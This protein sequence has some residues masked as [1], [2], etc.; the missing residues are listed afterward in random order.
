M[1]R[2]MVSNQGVTVEESAQKAIILVN[3]REEIL[4]L[5][6]EIGASDKTSILRFSPFP[7]EPKAELA[8]PT[9][10]EQ[11]GRLAAFAELAQGE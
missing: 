7:A 8:A 4:I 11:L 5:G 9:A 3:C 2:V 6:T 1:G 10:F